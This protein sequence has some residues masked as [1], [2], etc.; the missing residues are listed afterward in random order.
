MTDDAPALP[1]RFYKTASLSE[2][3]GGSGVALDSR[4]LR[5][6]GGAVFVAPTR[7]LAELCAAEWEAQGDFIVPASMPISQLAFATLDWT[8]KNRDQLA[9]YVKGFGETDLCCHRADFPVDLVAAQAAVWDPVVRWAA[10]EL[11]VSL[12]VVTGI[13]AARVDEETIARLRAHASALDDFHLT[14]LSQATGLAGSAL[15]GFAFVRRALSPEAAFEAAAFDNLWSLKRWGE[16]EEA[17][18]RLDRQRAEFEAIARYLGAL[19]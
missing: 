11:N 16:D 7:A 13:V 10:E 9:D 15:I 4:T 1:R 2:R 8:A 17:R 5:T 19:Q 3:D 6:P 12:P 14:A 18:V